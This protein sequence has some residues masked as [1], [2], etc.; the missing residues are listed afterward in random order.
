MKLFLA[1]LFAVLA[2]VCVGQ[3][4]GL[5]RG[6]YFAYEGGSVEV[7]VVSL[8]GPELGASYI[9]R[10]RVRRHDTAGKKTIS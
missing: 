7:C 6:L 4:I 10:L 8:T 5:D 1:A 9:V 3:R 2:T